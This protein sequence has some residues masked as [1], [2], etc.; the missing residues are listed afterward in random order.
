MGKFVPVLDAMV[1]AVCGRQVKGFAGL[2][3]AQGQILRP[4]PVGILLFVVWSMWF[5]VAGRVSPALR[6]RKRSMSA[7]T[8][9]SR[10]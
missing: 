9:N 7:G 2:L 10:Q 3:L 4:L 8:C 6:V 1:Q 5:R